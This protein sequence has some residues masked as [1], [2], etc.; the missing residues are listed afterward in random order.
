MSEAVDFLATVPLLEGRDEADL[1][2]LSRVL[3]RRTLP[4]GEVLW[5][6]GD[7]ARELV[8]IVEGRV[9][10]SLHAP[11]G[12]LVEIGR[13]GPGDM[14]GEI[15]LLEG[16]EHTMTVRA[17]EQVAVLGLGR[18]D[19]AA[20]LARPDASAFVLKRRLAVLFAGRLRNQLAQL[21]LTLGGEPPASGGDEPARALAGLEPCGPPDSRYLSRM[22]TFHDFD[23]VALW[24]FLTSGRY[25]M[26]PPGRT[27]LAEGAQSPACYLTINGAVEKVLLRGDR[28]VRVGLRRPRQGVRLREPHRRP[29]VAGDRDHPRANPP[30]R[31]SP[32]P[33]RAVV[34]EGGHDRARLP[35]RAAS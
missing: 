21:A 19:F 8:F 1:L 15:G 18:H 5:S 23:A 12:R 27:L 34:R 2:E 16:G 20:L 30:A 24:G 14:V 29:T 6:Q 13:A 32:R 22:A 33:V 28:R 26:A 7:R 25:A 17:T 11:G 3:R 4:A 31:A 9:S 10:A 35:R